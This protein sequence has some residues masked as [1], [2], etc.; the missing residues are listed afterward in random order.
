MGPLRTKFLNSVLRASRDN[1]TSSFYIFPILWV[2]ER[3]SQMK[4]YNLRIL[5]LI[6]IAFCPSSMLA[7]DQAGS[8]NKEQVSASMKKVEKVL[9]A[10]HIHPKITELEEIAGG[11][12]A[13]VAGLLQLRTDKK[14][15][16]LALR[17]EKYLLRYAT[18]EDVEKALE[19]DLSPGAN[20]RL[21]Q[22]IAVHIDSI[23]SQ[24][25]R[26]KIALLILERA[27]ADVQFQKYAQVL[28]GSKDVAVR[29]LAKEALERK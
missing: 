17:A 25:T 29:S 10:R 19:E 16:F 7:E 18:R 13:L 20:P 8:L 12:E 4:S 27:K 2:C 15:P 26:R 3:M 1:V 5:V 9:S 23:E 14:R 22:V 21:A 6:L 24:E 11:E 28:Y